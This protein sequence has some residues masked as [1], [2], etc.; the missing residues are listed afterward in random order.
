VNHAADEYARTSADGLRVHTNTAE[1]SHALLKRGLVGVWH[2]F[3]EQHM[4]R[5]LANA[6]FLW[7]TRRM[8]DGDRVVALIRAAEGKRLFYRRPVGVGS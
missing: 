8:S 6:D 1:C 4:H 5:Y 3:S 7:N 2:R